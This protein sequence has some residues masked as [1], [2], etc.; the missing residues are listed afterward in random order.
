MEKKTIKAIFV[1]GSPRKKWNTAQLL[2]S[3]MK[4]A[5]EAGA[6]CEMVHL[7]DI[8]FKGCKSCFACK[9]KNSKCNGICALKDDLRPVL[10]RCREADVI[11]LGSPV[12]YSFPTGEMRSFLERLMFP[13]GTYLYENGKHITLR[14]KVIPT[15]MIFTM[16]CP[17]DYMK[18]IGYPAILEENAKCL[19]DIF[20]YS[21]TLYA[22]N[23][24]QFSDYSRYDFNLFSEE[25]K[26]KHR[27]EHFP[28]DLQ[29]AYELGKRLVEKVER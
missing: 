20:G 21:E 9:L 4:G 11:V 3:A 23:T 17:E 5:Q 27:D 18:V 1:N 25:D 26:R 7:Y 6:E 10:E 12:Y 2:E 15:A 16:N 8:D 22:C 24:Y 13:V 29:N 14:D 28:I 19:S